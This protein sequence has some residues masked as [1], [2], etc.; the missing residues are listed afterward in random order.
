MYDV[1][2]ADLQ[3]SDRHPQWRSCNHE[4]WRAG[5]TVGPRCLSSLSSTI[6]FFLL[7]LGKFNDLLWKQAKTNIFKLSNINNWLA[8]LESVKKKGMYPYNS[9]MYQFKITRVKWILLGMLTKFTYKV[10]LDCL[11]PFWWS[12]YSLE[13]NYSLLVVWKKNPESFTLT[14]SD[15]ICGSLQ[16][17]QWGTNECIWILY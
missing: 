8:C 10:Y 9:L 6:C 15:S 3:R 7:Y 17:C 14:L 4:W 5:H 11:C 16:I 2:K 1:S 12:S 13:D